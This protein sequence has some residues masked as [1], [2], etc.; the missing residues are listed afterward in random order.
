VRSTSRTSFF[1]ASLKTSRGKEAAFPDV[2][3]VA[4][5]VGEQRYKIVSGRDL[6]PDAE[7]E[8][9]ANYV[10]AEQLDI[11]PGDRISITLQRQDERP[12]AKIDV[13]LVG[14]TAQVGAFESAT[15]GGFT[16][17]LQ[18][19]P[20][21]GRRWHA[22]TGTGDDN[23]GVSLRGGEARADAFERELAVQNIP[24]DGP[25]IRASSFTKGVQDL[26]RVP[27][28][29]LWLLCAFLAVTTLA[30]FSQLI[31]RETQLTAGEN[32]ALRA[33]GFSHRHLLSLS[34][35]R[36]G[37]IAV[38]G[39]VTSVGVA[40]IL[41]PLTPV[42]L[43]RIAEPNPGFTI[44]P[45][46]LAAGASATVIL[47]LLASLGPAWLAARAA[48]IAP[49]YRGER[50]S[51]IADGLARIGL[52]A[53][54]QSGVR[55][56]TR[57]GRGQ[58][59]VPVRTAALGMTIAIAALTAALAFASSLTR[60]VATPRL[61]GYSWDA[62]A[63]VNAFG[64]QDLAAKLPHLEKSIRDAMPDAR[65]WHGTV[66]SSASVET[67]NIGVDVSDG[68]R[69]SVIAG[70]AP[71]GDAEIAL[72]PRSLRQLRKTIGDTATVAYIFGPGKHG[73]LRRMRIV[74]TFAVPRVAFQGSLPGQSVAFTPQAAS[75]LNPGVPFADTVFVRFAPGTD[76]EREVSKLRSASGEDAFALVNRRT[77][78]TTV[79]NVSRMSA[80]PLILATIVGLL[81]AAT[82]AH[83]LTTTIRR[84]R[85]DL[86]ILKTLG[87]VRRQVHGTVAWQ[88][89]TLVVVALAIGVPLGVIAG[90]WGWRLFAEQLQVVPLP[91]MSWPVVAAI[92]AATIA[93]GNLIAL[94]PG[95]AA[96]RTP[97]AVV[98]R[99]E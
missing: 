40:I 45:R 6:H 48:S 96:A 83:A 35:I 93:L 7:N 28:I 85:R 39:A 70:R 26:N 65:L 21:F 3:L 97:A 64:P 13:T 37:A 18:M 79:G 11:R 42:G 52:P 9:I 99:T 29:A 32:P 19:T 53:S 75:A 31:G 41:S 12:S 49:A 54:V 44:A 95:L 78:S 55:L 69:P 8:T 30:V 62:G 4:G 10:M 46:L 24:T 50:G 5:P 63:I 58:R 90:R 60:L 20:A 67:L 73:I 36:A 59:S 88:C 81:G 16:T 71:R 80:L 77:Q 38:V 61:A 17:T 15:G 14:V 34:L 94:G 91:V 98:L 76:F 82:L 51:S 23:L 68:P 22:Y 43:A 66:F 25:P 92:V 86:A 57:S 84:R 72:D 27:A 1:F 2:F 74:G 87:F 33:L 47:V 56:A 89:T